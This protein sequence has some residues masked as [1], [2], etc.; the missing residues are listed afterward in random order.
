MMLQVKDSGN[1]GFL[2][3]Q[4]RIRITNKEYRSTKLR[5][6]Q[7]EPLHDKIVDFFWDKKIENYGKTDICS[8]YAITPEQVRLFQTL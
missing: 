1:F 7:I 8:L 5:M 2:D 6:F 4:W 3:L